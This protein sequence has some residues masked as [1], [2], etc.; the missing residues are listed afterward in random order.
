MSKEL[1]QGNERIDAVFQKLF[2]DSSEDEIVDDVERLTKA[3]ENYKRDYLRHLG[4]TPE[5]E[6]LS[7]ALYTFLEPTF[8][9]GVEEKISEIYHS[10]LRKMELLKKHVNC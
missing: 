3:Y 5:R 8:V 6:N 1:G 4:F 7:I 2:P 9:L 10:S